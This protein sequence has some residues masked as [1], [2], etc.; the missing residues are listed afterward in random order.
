MPVTDT[1]KN[2]SMHLCDS[3]N[4]V[5]TNESFPFMLFFLA[6]SKYAKVLMMLH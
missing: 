5:L 4:H 6:G 1:K 3:V 2:P